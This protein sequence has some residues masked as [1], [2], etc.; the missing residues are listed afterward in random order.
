MIAT[1]F[2]ELAP[3]PMRAQTPPPGA[4][5]ADALA[6]LADLLGP[7]AV[8]ADDQ[9]RV[10]RTRGKSTPDLLLARA[11]DTTDAPDVVIRPASHDEVAAVLA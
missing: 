5:G 3:T 6:E 7:D 10:L 8:R 4:L 9:T 2:G 1:L 11:G